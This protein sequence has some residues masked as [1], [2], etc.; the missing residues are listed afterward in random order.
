MNS[1]TVGASPMMDDLRK[2]RIA[3]ARRRVDLIPMWRA[4]SHI[5]NEIDATG[6]SLDQLIDMAHGMQEASRGE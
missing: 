6:Y 3:M 5:V 4:V 1:V 2:L